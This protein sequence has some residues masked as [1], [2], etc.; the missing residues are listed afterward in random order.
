MVVPLYLLVV[1]AFKSQSDIITSPFALDW[2][3]LSFEHMLAAITSPDFNVISAYGV[4]TVFVVVVNL[5]SLVVTIPV[6]YVIAR[7]VRRW[8]RGLLFVL[9]AGMFIPGQVLVIPVI[10]V[11]RSIGLMGTV[12]G[13][14]LFETATTIP[15]SVFLFTSFIQS[16][17]R[18][19]DEAAKIDGAH[20]LR[21]LVTVIVPLM[22]P[23]IATAVVIHTISIWADFVNPQ[24]ILGPGSGI[25][26][27]TTGV[28]YAIS[29][30]STDYTIVYP[31]LLLAIAPILL[32][33]VLMQKQIVGGLTSGALKG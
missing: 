22:R 28:Y 5:L 15:L 33:F 27:V 3:R 32:F 19:L 25:Y 17:P 18:E 4:T 2:S 6:S 14:I 1:N 8:Q 23:A 10:Y 7:A 24:I 20:R 29:Q 11:L 9:L 21:V 26:T 12:P 31:N 13:F 30:Y 16:I